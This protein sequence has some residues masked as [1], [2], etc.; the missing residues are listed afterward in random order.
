[1]HLL[2]YTVVICKLNLPALPSLM[3]LH[4]PGGNKYQLHSVTTVNFCSVKVFLVLAGT[5]WHSNAQEKE[6]FL[7]FGFPLIRTSDFVEVPLIPDCIWDTG[8]IT[9]T[10]SA[11]AYANVGKKS[12]IQ[13]CNI[14]FNVTSA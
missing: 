2:E 3:V 12:C 1:M 14:R 6:A 13:L 10:W 7:W 11:T 8:T 9:D 5:Q 4:V